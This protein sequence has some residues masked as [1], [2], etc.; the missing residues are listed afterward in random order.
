MTRWKRMTME[1]LHMASYRHEVGSL[2]VMSLIAI[3]LASM[4]IMFAA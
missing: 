1:R 3:I 4:I 2:L